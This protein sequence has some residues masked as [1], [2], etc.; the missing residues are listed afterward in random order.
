MKIT[1]LPSGEVAM[2]STSWV[3]S[4]RLRE[5]GDRSPLGV[6]RGSLESRIEDGKRWMRSS[7]RLVQTSDI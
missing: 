6:C 1:L 2:K 3:D 4:L 5:K 7:V